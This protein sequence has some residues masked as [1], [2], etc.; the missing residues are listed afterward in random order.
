VL[1]VW[2]VGY[3]GVAFDTIEIGAPDQSVAPYWVDLAMD[4]RVF[5]F[6]AALC[7]GSS[8]LFG[9]APALHI[10]KTNLNDVL[11][12]GG[13]S[14]AGGVR[15]RRWTGA[16]MIGEL[17]LALIL[18]SGAG[19]LVRSFFIHYNAPLVVDPRPLTVARTELPQLEYPT[20]QARKA[21]VEALNERFASSLRGQAP[22]VVAGDI[23]LVPLFGPSRTLAIDGRPSAGN[24]KPPSISHLYV[25]DGYFEVLG[26][27]M[28]QGRAFTPADGAAGQETAIVSQ[29]FATTFFPGESALGRR[30]RLTP[31]NSQGP[32]PPWMTIVGVAPTIPETAIREADP[33]L[34]Y[35][36]LRGEAAPGRSVSLIVRG[37]APAGAVAT[38][39][40]ANLGALNPDL[41]LYYVQP[42]TA[43]VAQT[44]YS[45]RM[46]G[47]LF[48]LLAVIG[49]VLTSVGLSA[50]T[51]RGV[52]ERTHEIG[53]R[54]A[55]GAQTREVVWLFLRRTL[56]QLAIGLALG[57]GGALSVGR[58]IQ[59]S[60]VK[61]GPRDPMTLT[62]ICVLL[63]VVALLAALVPARRAARVD[64]VVA[65]R[66][67]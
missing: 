33:P 39:L 37:N 18:L 15:V 13:R 34:V 19:L 36:P 27:R 53:V 9:L 32:P 40:R 60:L 3:F 26:L 17:A 1:S 35:V 56:I 63:V 21:F 4:R 20:P 2:G 49:V 38:W 31:A 25:G 65:L 61:I 30:I 46:I 45:L 44:R 50:L 22:T 28:I 43:I 58:L 5:A 52:A 10:S 7:L 11:K 23:P 24:D 29:R 48:A 51:A 64:P 42:M 6:V 55:L 14:A 12:D 67:E 8:M 59:G 62:A 54:M 47:S 57:L 66:Y 16:L 41:P